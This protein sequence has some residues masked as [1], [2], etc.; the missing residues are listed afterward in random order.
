MDGW[1]HRVFM[2]VLGS[3]ISKR[4]VW[5]LMTNW[6]PRSVSGTQLYILSMALG[7]NDIFGKQSLYLS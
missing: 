3:Y 1:E 5:E 7:Q 2:G 4:G 6:R